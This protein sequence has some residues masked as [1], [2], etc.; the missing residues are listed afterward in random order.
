MFRRLAMIASQFLLFSCGPT[1]LIPGGALYGESSPPP[2]DWNW[3]AEISTIQLETRPSDPYSVNI[4]TVG[5]E[6]NLYVHAGPNRSNWV[7]NIEADPAV[8]VRI[9]QK[10]YDLT[11]LRIT[12]ETEFNLFANAYE[13]KYG[14]RPRNETISAIYLFNLVPRQHNFSARELFD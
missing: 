5:I 11:A 2:S 13:K 10:I 3:T 7:E 12:D 9:N 4:W 1:L 6:D 14:S 8:R